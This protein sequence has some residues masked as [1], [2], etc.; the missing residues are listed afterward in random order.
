VASLRRGM[1]GRYFGR[2]SLSCAPGS[3]NRP[4]RLAST[5]SMSAS[6]ALLDLGLEGNV[7]IERVMAGGV[8]LEVADIAVDL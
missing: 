5:A 7:A 8:G 1:P 3:I 4:A 6:A 2:G